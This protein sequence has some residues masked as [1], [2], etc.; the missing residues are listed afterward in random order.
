MSIPHLVTRGFGNGN[1]LGSIAQIVT[2][3]FIVSNQA[4][5]FENSSF[6]INENAPV[7]TAIGTAQ[8]TDADSDTLT[9]SILSGNTNSDL[10]I[11]SAT[12]VISIAKT[13]NYS[14]TASYSLT[15]Q[16]S[17][18]TSTDT[19]TITITVIDYDVD[20]AQSST[21]LL[22]PEIRVDYP[23][24]SYDLLLHY[25]REIAIKFCEETWYWQETISNI[26]LFSYQDTYRIVPTLGVITDIKDVKITDSSGTVKT[27]VREQHDD[28][29]CYNQLAPDIIE[30]PD[31]DNMVP[32]PMQARV[33]LRPS[34]SSVEIPE[35][36]YEQHYEALVEGIRW[37]VLAMKSE[38]WF[39]KNE[40]EN[41]R[42]M[43]EGSMARARL[44]VSRQYSKQ[45]R[46]VT[47]RKRDF[48]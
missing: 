20:T 27:L 1:L 7:G 42:E 4:P 3:G 36:V 44:E 45:P 33:A 15:V 23:T 41:Y 19:A 32:G 21:V 24:L 47:S 31:I 26:E 14:V 17:D 10:A 11:D 37:K 34:R 30:L 16:V 9:Y 48:Y 28:F 43:F 38:P 22:F 46:R 40:S 39:D 13:L 8:A 2:N 35:P 25:A 5:V 29:W 18:G 6:S 12:G